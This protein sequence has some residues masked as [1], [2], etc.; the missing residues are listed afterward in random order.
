MAE[1]EG[2]I[3]NPFHHF[4]K[5]RGAFLTAC[6]ENN[7]QTVDSLKSLV[8]AGFHYHPDLSTDHE[9]VYIKKEA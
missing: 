1:K 9:F 5:A 4:K 8:F 2:P 3:Q 7:C 6:M